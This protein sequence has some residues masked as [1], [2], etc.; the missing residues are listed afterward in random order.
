[1]TIIIVNKKTLS[2]LIVCIFLVLALGSTDGD[3]EPEVIEEEVAEENGEKEGTAEETEEA[4]EVFEIG[5]T[6]AM[7]DLAFT[8]HGARWYDGSE[9]MQP[10]EGNRYL[11][12]DA[13]VENKSDEGKTISSM[14]MFS[15]YD[16]E[17]R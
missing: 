5:E 2:L 6:V 14:M 16:D 3:D 9:F 4:D 8:L 11:L 12:I 10:D 7:G 15:V 13:T 17:Y 1:M